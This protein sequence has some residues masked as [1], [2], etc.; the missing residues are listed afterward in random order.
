MKGNF[1]YLLLGIIAGFVVS[2]QPGMNS[3]LDRKLGGPIIASTI[4]FLVG[5][6][7]LILLIMVLRISL[8][9]WTSI[10]SV[11]WWA[12]LGGLLGAFFVIITVI[13]APKVGA[14]TLMAVV[15]AGQ[16]VASLLYDQFGLLGFPVHPVSLLRIIGIIF[17]FVGLYFV[18]KF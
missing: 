14:T 4:S 16:V 7:A 3:V 12:W 15:L 9:D 5:S 10:K 6:I 1:I 18:N 11:P 17:I 13:L 2:A 8:P